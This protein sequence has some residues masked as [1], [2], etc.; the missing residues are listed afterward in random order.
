VRIDGSKRHVL[1]DLDTDLAVAVGVTAAN[2]AEAQVADQITADLA[3]QHRTLG[4]FHI[5]RA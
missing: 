1:T 4:E 2:V 3:A 5:D